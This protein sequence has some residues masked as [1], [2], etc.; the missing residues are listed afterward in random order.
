LP[1]RND[2]VAATAEERHL[3][4]LVEELLCR[5]RPMRADNEMVIEDID[6]DEAAAFLAGVDSLGNVGR[7]SSTRKRERRCGVVGRSEVRQGEAGATSGM[8]CS[9]QCCQ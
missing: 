8:G 2:D 6:K 3:E 4:L 7:S 1:C 9:R 5:A